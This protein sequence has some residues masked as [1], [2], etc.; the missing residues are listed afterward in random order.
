M[1]NL[2]TAV[3]FALL[4]VSLPVQSQFDNF[5]FTG[6]HRLNNSLSLNGVAEIQKNGILQLTNDTSRLLGHAFYSFPVRLKDSI[7]GSA[8]SFSTTFAFATVPEY[9]RLGG[10]G[11]AFTIS[12]SKELKGALPR[13]Y[14][15]L[16]NFE[17]M[18]N[19][20]NHIM[21]VEFDTVQDLEFGDI[22]DNHVGI[23][24][25]NLESNASANASYYISGSTMEVINLKSGKTIQAWIDYDSQRNV[26]NVTISPSSSKPT[27]P[28]LSFKSDLSP[29]LNDFM[30]VGFSA[31][32]GLLASSHYV[33]GWSFAIN[34]QA[35]TL[36]LASLPS[37]PQPKNK[38]VALK[39]GIPVSSIIILTSAIL[40]L[41]I[42]II[43]QIKN[44]DIIEAWELDIGPHRH[45]YEELRKATKGFKE[46]DLLGIG[47]FG[48]VYRG[49]LPKS[50]TQ[51]A[52]KRI[53]QQS[54][55]G[56]REFVS[57]I[58]SMG[59][60]RHRNLVQLVGWSRRR[61]DLLLVY[62]YMENGSLDKLLFENSEST[63]SWEERFKIIKG[64][65]HGLLY[66]HEGYEQVVIHRDV[67]A[68]NVLLDG[69]LNG[70]LG[71]FGLA[72]LY[73]HG[74]KPST[75]RVVGTLGY[76]APEVSRTGKATTSSDVF[77]FGALLL[78]TACG[79]RPVDPAAE[80]VLVD[81]VWTAWHEGRIYDVV[82]PALDEKYDEGEVV[83]VLKLGLLCSAASPV[84]RPS[85]RQ[86]VTY[87]EGEGGL[88]EVLSTPVS[89]DRDN[90]E[91][92]GFDEI[93]GSYGWTSFEKGNRSSAMENRDG[94]TGSASFSTPPI[95]L[96]HSDTGSTKYH[97]SVKI[98]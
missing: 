94:I 16:L 29:I 34:G 50:K 37:L 68:S 23:D 42:Y 75:T 31:S 48:R 76:L 53:S 39:I 14:L 59:R 41:S 51:I 18:G 8:F 81:W 22:S 80:V 28:L 1:A 58:S 70:R 85:M 82:D 12:P 83:I 11:L 47:G 13:Q 98:V 19:S 25:N 33:F 86:V 64:V 67:K 6:F 60:L 4:F 69:E 35:Q 65:A 55:Q 87:L 91:D 46:K 88:P 96:L 52:V 62:E 24:I 90:G 40:L 36:D 5:T 79:R 20:S 95:S 63:L 92:Y 93:V 73:E 57:E 49:T 2:L 97:Q 30:Y 44:R 56:L 45:T 74:T 78:E 10:H 54:K 89:Y 66:L 15:G 21:A 27:T 9:P 38:H 77:S 71:D 32:T 72:R 3:C 43:R 26:L 84:A 7:N 61:G 17:N